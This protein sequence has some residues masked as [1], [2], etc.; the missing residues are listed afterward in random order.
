MVLGLLL[1]LPFFLMK[2]ELETEVLLNQ[3]T[4]KW[5]SYMLRVLITSVP[6]NCHGVN[7][8]TI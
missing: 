2:C 3:C 1:P 6:M 7:R 8:V 4:I 5:Y